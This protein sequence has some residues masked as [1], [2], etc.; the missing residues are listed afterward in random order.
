VGICLAWILLRL[1]YQDPPLPAADFA[2]PPLA[3]N[4]FPAL[5]IS[6]LE[7]GSNQVLEGFADKTGSL[8]KMIP[9]VHSAILVEHPQATFLIDTGLGSAIDQEVRGAHWWNRTLVGNYEK[10]RPLVEQEPFKTLGKKLDFIIVTHGHWDHLSGALDFPEIPIY[11]LPEEIEFLTKTPRP[12]LHGIFA[13]QVATLQGRFKPIALQDA[14][15]E[16]FKQSLDW[17]GDG[18][19]LIVPL[20]GHTPG[21]LGVFLNLAPNQRFLIVGDALWRVQTNG[22]PVARSFLAEWFADQE[23]ETA[24]KTRK[25]LEALVDRRK[26]ILLVPIHDP[27]ALAKINASTYNP[28]PAP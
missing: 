2:P 27:Q 6:V 28:S 24:R 5:N 14:P 25:A 3:K 21:S 22:R 4:T 23:R 12:H 20:P 18:S 11:F 17:F 16:N 9:L 8:R 26:E 7:T 19:V 15:Y 1:P 13:S 10:A